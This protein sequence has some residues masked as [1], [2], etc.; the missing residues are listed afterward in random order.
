M[1]TK[2]WYS[3]MAGSL[4][5]AH[6]TSC[7][8]SVENIRGCASKVCSKPPRCGKQNPGQKLL[9]HKQPRQKKNCQSADGELSVGDDHQ[10]FLPDVYLAEYGFIGHVRVRSPWRSSSGEGRS[11]VY[12]PAR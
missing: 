1:R 12:V 9:L 4:S 3:I 7:C 11:Q 10:S 6:T 5:A 8:H 2:S